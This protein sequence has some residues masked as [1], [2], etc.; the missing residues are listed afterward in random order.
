MSDK[1]AEHDRRMRVLSSCNFE[2]EQLLPPLERKYGSE[3]VEMALAHRVSRLARTLL[4][5]VLGRGRRI[6]CPA[7]LFLPTTKPTD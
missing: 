4:A 2:L 6:A 7:F 5:S 3:A 1:P